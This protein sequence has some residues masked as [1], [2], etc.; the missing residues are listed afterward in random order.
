MHEL[1][2]DVN[3]T[4]DG[5]V[6]T[7]TVTRPNTNPVNP[8]AN[9][10]ASDDPSAPNHPIVERPGG[11][12][13]DDD[14]DEAYR[15]P[16]PLKRQ[17]IYDVR[18]HSDHNHSGED[19]DGSLTQTTFSATPKPRAYNK[20]PTPRVRPNTKAKLANSL[21]KS[22][23]LLKTQA[24]EALDRDKLRAQTIAA[25]DAAKESALVTAARLDRE[26]LAFRFTTVP[27]QDKAM[28]IF[29]EGWKEHF[30]DNPKAASEAILLFEHEDKCRTFVNA[31]A[32]LRWSWLALSLG[33]TVVPN[34]EDENDNE[35]E[36]EIGIE[37]VNE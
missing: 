33:Y 11:L 25:H 17:G 6:G 22:S 31:H 1:F 30:G 10:S 23:E 7:Q 13:D 12:S 34:S 32:E 28:A 26:S 36:K 24:A 16:P 2:G 27:S 14:D 21:D 8:P 5:I 3:A 35:K 9:D 4:A 18:H 37:K 29:N 15:L 20:K 19:S